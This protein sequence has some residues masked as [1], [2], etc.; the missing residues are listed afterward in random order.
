VPPDRLELSA[1]LDAAL[2]FLREEQR[3]S[4]EFPTFKARDAALVQ[5]R[6]FD[7]TP[8]ATTYLLHALSFVERPHVREMAAEALDFLEAE[9]ESHGVWRYWTSEHPQHGFIP[10]DLD[11]TCCVA[12]VLRRWGRSLPENEE[13]IL[14]NRNR[15]GL[16]YTWL[17]PR[18]ARTRSRA[19]WSVTLRQAPIVRRRLNFWRLTEARPWDVDCVVNAN[20]LHYLG[21]RA[22]AR[23]VADLL[24]RALREGRA[25]CCDK[26][27]L[28]ACAFYYAVSRAYASGVTAL[29]PL[30]EPLT[31]HAEGALAKTEDLAAAE[32]ALAA[33]ALLNLGHR[34]AALDEAIQHLAATQGEDGAWPG[35]ALYWG[36]PKR[37]YGW[38]SGALTTGLCVEALARF[39]A[40]PAAPRQ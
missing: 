12:A 3:P 18:P 16:F 7:S 2:S 15:A 33:C 26:W 25:G 19:Y 34:A 23:P 39:I 4:G 5:E 28:N 36:G 17:V 20:V 24:A 10:P 32:V 30:R 9:M 14:A 27:H 8:F 38:G 31:V 11:D 13:L 6:Q 22:E 29:E 21:D 35:Y 37:N 1:R 40:E